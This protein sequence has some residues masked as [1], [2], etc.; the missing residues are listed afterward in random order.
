[1]L[2]N[3]RHSRELALQRSFMERFGSLP[4]FP[5]PVVE[6]RMMCKGAWSNRSQWISDRG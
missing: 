6:A 4:T 2:R 1:M 5:T 3:E